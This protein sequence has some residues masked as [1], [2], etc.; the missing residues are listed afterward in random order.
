MAV[1]G[2]IDRQPRVVPYRPIFR[3]MQVFPCL[4]QEDGILKRS[5]PGVNIDTPCAP[6]IWLDV[7]EPPTYGKRMTNKSSFPVGKLP[8]DVLDALLK[9]A[10]PHPRLIVGPQIGEDA[11]V[12]DMGDRYLVVKSDPITFVEHHIGRYAVH[13]N[14]N[15]IVCMGATPLWFLMTLLL[16]EGRADEAMIKRIWE[17]VG[18][19][20]TELGITLCGGHTEITSGL[21]FPILSGHMLGEV[22]K[23]NLIR[24]ADACTDDLI[25]L[26]RPIPVEGTA[27]LADAKYDFLK[28]IIDIE[29]LKNAKRYLVS[30]GISIVSQALAAA[31]TGRVHAMHDPT[32]GGLA[33]GIHEMTEAA[34]L[35]AIVEESQI[36]ISFEGEKICEALGLDPLGVITSG[37]LLLAVPA[38]G[39]EI[40]RET[41]IATGAMGVR[42]GKLCPPES[43]VMI[44][45]GGK[46]SPLQRFDSDE[47]SKVL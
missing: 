9:N 23:E 21:E 19:T 45:R 14:A 40:V 25:L 30:P 46:T 34:G 39:E 1:C 11:A 38:E 5:T 8:P 20:C 22:S 32:E 17:E 42:I 43:G 28:S 15:D 31:G 10:N 6:D 16:P 35:G 44:Q 33:T 29:I 27:I 41:L 2:A 24:G 3:K 18:D 36:P 7:A 26:T 4:Y 37:A 13:V 47:I 12:I